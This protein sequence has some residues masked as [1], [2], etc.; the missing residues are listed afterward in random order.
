MFK[1][2]VSVRDV[3]GIGDRVGPVPT[4]QVLKEYVSDR[5]MSDSYFVKNCDNVFVN[6]NDLIRNLWFTRQDV[7]VV[8]LRG[9]VDYTNVTSSRRE[10]PCQKNGRTENVPVFIAEHFMSR[11]INQDDS[12]NEAF[13]AFIDEFIALEFDIFKDELSRFTIIKG[14]PKLFY[15]TRGIPTL[16]LTSHRVGLHCSIVIYS[17][18]T[19]TAL[20]EYEDMEDRID[21]PV[22]RLN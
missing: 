16:R 1:D 21:G 15:K 14:E 7:A 2:G 18:L 11:H 8:Q 13:S 12:A 6:E 5:Y 17:G 9:A 3:L 22:A 10:Y 4:P 20:K 19:I